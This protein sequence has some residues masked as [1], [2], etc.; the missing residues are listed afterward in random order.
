MLGVTFPTQTPVEFP[1]RRILVRKGNK[2]LVDPRTL[3]KSI[4]FRPIKTPFEPMIPDPIRYKILGAE[5]MKIAR[6]IDDSKITCNN[7]IGKRHLGG[8]EGS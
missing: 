4:D 5:L 8:L 2:I 3:L 7:R 1:F 6:S